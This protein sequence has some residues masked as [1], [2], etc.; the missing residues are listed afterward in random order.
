MKAPSA[1]DSPP[2]E[3]SQAMPRQSTMIESR[4]NSRLRLRT[5]CCSNGGTMSQAAPTIRPTTTAAFRRVNST[6]PMALPLGVARI[7]V[8]SIMGTTARSW[9]IRIATVAWPWNESL[10]PRSESAFST[11]AVLLRDSKNP[12]KIPC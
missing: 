12:Q 3:V 2:S 11:M 5:M 1:R 6:A 4:N 10:S 8:M 9:K 7:G